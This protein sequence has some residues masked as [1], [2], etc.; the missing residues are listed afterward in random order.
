VRKF[1]ISKVTIYGRR[2]KISEI[3]KNTIKMIKIIFAIS[4]DAPAIP[5]NPKTAAIIA[6]IRN[7][8]LQRNMIIYLFLLANDH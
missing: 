7:V 1:Q 5:P 3:T 8:I 4:A 6:I 2:P